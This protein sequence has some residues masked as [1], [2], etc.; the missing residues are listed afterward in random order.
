MNT[1]LYYPH[2]SI[3]SESLL[4]TAL[5]LW[6]KLEYIVPGKWFRQPNPSHLTGPRRDLAE[7]MEIIGK[8]VVPSA[9]EQKLVHEEIERLILG[10]LPKKYLFAPKEENYLIYAEKFGGQTWKLLRDRELVGGTVQFEKQGRRVHDYSLNPELGLMLMTLLAKICAGSTALKVT[11]AKYASKAQG[12]YFTRLEG[13]D[14]GQN[15][16]EHETLVVE[17]FAPRLPT[18]GVT[19]RQLIAIR[20]NEDAF[21]KELRTKYRDEVDKFILRISGVVQGS[22][23]YERVWAEFHG[24]L[25]AEL[26]ELDRLLQRERFSFGSGFLEKIA[27]GISVATVTYLSTHSAWAAVSS[28]VTSIGLS[29][30][31]KI[32]G[33]IPATNDKREALLRGKAAGWLYAVQNPKTS[34]RRKG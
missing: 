28:G 3:E 30:G 16:E 2:T 10:G 27:P 5:L 15:K 14:L 20:Q 11:D 4:K 22:R 32:L 13:G 18:Q 8:P 1:A 12:A 17:T 6:D 34:K 29:G 23:D 31:L 9:E 26:D 19:L 24:K 33:S 25:K 21:L 7:A